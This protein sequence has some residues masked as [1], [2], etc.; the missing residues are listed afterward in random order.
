MTQQRMIRGVLAN[1][2][3]WTLVVLTVLTHGWALVLVAVIAL[4]CAV[5]Y[6]RADWD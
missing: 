5:F 1:F 6:L 3:F 2:A 4:A